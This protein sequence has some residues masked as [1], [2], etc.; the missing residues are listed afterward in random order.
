MAVVFMIAYACLPPEYVTKQNWKAA[1]R[2]YL[3][4]DGAYGLWPQLI[5]ASCIAIF[6]LEPFASRNDLVAA[7]I[8]LVAIVFLVTLFWQGIITGGKIR[9]DLFEYDYV[10]NR[11]QMFAFSY[12]PT[13]KFFALTAFA[14]PFVI[15]GLGL[16]IDGTSAAAAAIAHRLVGQ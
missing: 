1:Q 6:S 2:K 10:H 13:I 3:Y 7:A 15:A 4:A 12:P 9:A 5:L 11:P 14:L 8:G 16:L